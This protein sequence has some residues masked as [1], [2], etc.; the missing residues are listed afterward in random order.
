MGPLAL[1]LAYLS[2]KRAKSLYPWQLV[3]AVVEMYFVVCF[4][5][6]FFITKGFTPSML[7]NNDGVKVRMYDNLGPK[8]LAVGWNMATFFVCSHLTEESFSKFVR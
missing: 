7:A 8:L 2:A 4:F 5:I 1:Y 3:Y 6:H